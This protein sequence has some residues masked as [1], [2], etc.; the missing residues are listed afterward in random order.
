M[1]IHFNVIVRKLMTPLPVLG[2]PGLVFVEKLLLVGDFPF[3]KRSDNLPLEG[4][5][6]AIVV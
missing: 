1:V 3:N 4:N 2:Y 6:V 5:I